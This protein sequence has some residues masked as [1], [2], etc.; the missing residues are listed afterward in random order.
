MG[1]VFKLDP[2]VAESTSSN[3]RETVDE[4]E[5]RSTRLVADVASE[6]TDLPN[7]QYSFRDG[8]VSALHFWQKR[9][10]D[11]G[12]LLNDAC[13]YID[14]HVELAQQADADAASGLIEI[15]D[16]IDP[17]NFTSDDYRDVTGEEPTGSSS[18]DAVGGDRVGENGM[19]I[20]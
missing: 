19:M 10:N 14:T 5:A 7:D 18:G 20:Q 3:I 6:M 16:S 8:L 9:S 4:M 12:D 17:N 13:D 1:K 15:T 11:S 2:E